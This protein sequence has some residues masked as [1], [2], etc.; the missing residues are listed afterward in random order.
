[1]S[2]RTCGPFIVVPDADHALL[3]MISQF[4][5]ARSSAMY[6]LQVGSDAMGQSLFLQHIANISPKCLQ[7]SMPCAGCDFTRKGRAECKEQ[8]QGIACCCRCLAHTDR[9]C[10]RTHIHAQ[11][12]D[13][14][15]ICLAPKWVR[16]R[17]QRTWHYGPSD[18]CSINV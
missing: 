12:R 14:Q 5:L 18:P 11:S 3:R 6:Q 1:M 7:C 13:F 16:T 4:G 2:A 8:R 17:A 9:P 15:Q 10:A